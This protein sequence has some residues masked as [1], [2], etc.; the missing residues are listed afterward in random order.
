MSN[1]TQGISEMDSALMAEFAVP[2]LLYTDNGIRSVDG[3]FDD[4][5]SFSR[6]SG[7][8]FV[9]DSDPTLSVK[10]KD[11]TGLKIRDKLNVAGKDWIIVKPP[12]PDGTGMTKLTL[13]H[14]N[15][16]KESKSSI[17]Y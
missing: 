16:Q 3:V 2:V 1:W 8:G 11:A 10:D 9:S 15:G 12:A 14:F 6:V 5:A 4:P 17:Q 13:G 7:G